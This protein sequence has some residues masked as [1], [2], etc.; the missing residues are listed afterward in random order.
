MVQWRFGGWRV[1][2]VAPRATPVHRGS[3]GPTHKE[4]GWMKSA[5]DDAVPCETEKGDSTTFPEVKA[6]AAGWMSGT[7]A[8]FYRRTQGQNE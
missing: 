3:L 2:L 4:R 7:R 1:A 8:P 5:G 6:V